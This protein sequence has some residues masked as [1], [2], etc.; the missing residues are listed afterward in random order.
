VAP[1]RVTVRL[2]SVLRL[3]TATLSWA[4]TESGA[5]DNSHQRCDE[6]MEV[7]LWIHG[8]NGRSHQN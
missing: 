7:S 1:K 8:F 2:K 5:R 6:A 4:E 3:I